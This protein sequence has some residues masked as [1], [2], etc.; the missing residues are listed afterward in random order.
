[1]TTEMNNFLRIAN[2]VLKKT[3]KNETQ[4]KSWAAK[5]YATWKQRKK[6]KQ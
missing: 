2:A 5:M 6:S 3:Y 4:R 1:M